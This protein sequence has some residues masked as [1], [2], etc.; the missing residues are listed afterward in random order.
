VRAGKYLLG[1]VLPLLAAG[2]PLCALAGSMQW[3]LING[4]DPHEGDGGRLV[5]MTEGARTTLMFGDQFMIPMQ[6]VLVGSLWTRELPLV[7]PT[8]MY[9]PAVAYDSARKVI[10][11]FGGFDRNYQPSAET[12]E[13]DGLIWRRRM[14]VGAPPARGRASLA[15]DATRGVMVLFGGFGVGDVY[16]G[17]TW[18]Y[19]GTLWRE[20]SPLSPRP[21]ARS[22]HSMAYDAARGRVV[23]AFG[24]NATLPGMNDTWLYDGVRWV[25]AP[26]QPTL[27][28]RYE[29]AAAYDAVRQAVFAFGGAGLGDTLRWTGT[30]WQTVNVPS[31]PMGRFAHTMAFDAARGKILMF[32][33]EGANGHT[34]GDLWAFDGAQWT[35]I[36][37]SIVVP[38]RTYSGAALD[39]ATDALV[40]YGGWTCCTVGPY[41][42][43]WQMQGEEWSE[44]D[45]SANP[46]RR[47]GHSMTYDPE[48]GKIRVL[49]GANAQ[50]TRLADTWT[51]DASSRQW[52]ELV[53]SPSPAARVDHR[54]V[55]DSQRRGVLIFGGAPDE[56]PNLNDTWILRNRNWQQVFTLNP[57]SGRYAMGLAYDSWRGHVV[58][59]GGW[60]DF[61]PNAET[62]VL[63]GDS[64]RQVLASGPGK[65]AGPAMAFDA[66]RGRTL[67]IGGSQPETS[68][69]FTWEFD[70]VSWVPVA[71]VFSPDMHRFGGNA[72]WDAARRAVLLTA[73]RP[74]GPAHSYNDTWAYGWD[75][76]DDLK[77]GGFDNCPDVANSTQADGDADG[78]G[79]P[80]D[81][82]PNDVGSWRLPPE[83]SALSANG[84][85][86]T[87]LVWGDLSATAGPAVV[88]D[89]VTGSL[90][91][92]PGPDPFG[93]AACLAYGLS[94]SSALDERPSPFPGDGYWY[95]VRG[96]NICGA[97]TFGAHREA[98]EGQAV[99][100]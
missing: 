59:H 90:S 83:V 68:D 56:G 99:C 21:S 97:G 60:T 19:D 98:L 48:E 30:A 78:A 10:V 89:V 45:V 92:F 69:E 13:Y 44:V 100:P 34:L 50:T 2:V 57:P 23:L 67:L 88:Y 54:A 28:L 31:S 11:Q 84:H 1:A 20:I 52:T 53:T 86:P 72:V 75:A 12:W 55:W 65:R 8:P 18:E 9:K 51:F 61:G 35:E 47:E 32:G 27:L 94:V 49:G 96:S 16:L 36:P 17:D 38:H 71:T 63:D 37:R 3:Q 25:K 29:S 15:F 64:W 82:A 81:C 62:W 91:R 40:A 7:T 70:G 87:S 77:V 5:H 73:G 43:T 42:E 93:D 79:D 66:E 95:L 6:W 80:C 39:V 14:D 74:W 4:G 33:G 46:G 85:F 24:R 41:A 76:D 58:L 26:N 22:D